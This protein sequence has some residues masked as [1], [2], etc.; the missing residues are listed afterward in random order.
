M[1]EELALKLTKLAQKKDHLIMLEYIH[2]SLGKYIKV[3]K[4]EI[5]ELEKKLKEP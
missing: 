2:S 1:N 3:F 4:A 5:A